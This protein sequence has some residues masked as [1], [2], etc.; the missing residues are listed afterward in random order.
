[1]YLKKHVKKNGRIFLMA[2]MIKKKDIPEPLRLRRLDIW[3]NWKSNMKTP[4]FFLTRGFRS[5]NRKRRSD[6]PLFPWSFLMTKNLYTVKTNEKSSVMLYLVRP[7]MNSK[8]IS[9]L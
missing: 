3:M 7:T 4:S 6:Y 9:S 8:L 2:I 5:L 1:M